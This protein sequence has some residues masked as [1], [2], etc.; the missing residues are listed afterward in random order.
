MAEGNG[1]SEKEKARERYLALREQALKADK[2]A[3][4]FKVWTDTHYLLAGG[5]ILAAFIYLFTNW[6]TLSGANVALTICIWTLAVLVWVALGAIP[7][8]KQ[9]AS[10]KT[11]HDLKQQLYDLESKYHL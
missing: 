11:L 5:I 9:L 7:T 3:R 6:T 4:L 8:R 1:K 10:R 2:R